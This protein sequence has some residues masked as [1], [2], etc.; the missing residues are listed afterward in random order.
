MGEGVRFHRSCKSPDCLQE[1][2]VP[3]GSYTHGTSCCIVCVPNHAAGTA[4]LMMQKST[5]ARQ[6]ERKKTG[7]RRCSLWLRGNLRKYRGNVINN[8]E[9]VKVG[10]LIQRP[11]Q[12]SDAIW[13]A[14][15][16]PPYGKQ[17]RK[18]NRFFS[19]GAMDWVYVT[20]H[21]NYFYFHQQAKS[22][23]CFSVVS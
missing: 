7:R 13:R 2:S 21:G 6:K 15:F 10:H 5:S 20:A 12:E 17:S 16:P 19:E 18:E 8:L 22:S 1:P 9:Y 11:N 23:Q 4:E 3:T 14:H